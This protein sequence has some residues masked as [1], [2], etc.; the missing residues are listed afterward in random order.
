MFWR[1]KKKTT[2]EAVPAQAAVQPLTNN[3]LLDRWLEDDFAPA[4]ARISS[5]PADKIGGLF[6]ASGYRVDTLPLSATSQDK[7]R[8]HLQ[9]MVD[10]G[11]ANFILNVRTGETFH[12]HL[13]GHPVEISPQKAN[14]AVN[15]D[16]WIDLYCCAVLLRDERAISRLLETPDDLHGKAHRPADQ[17]DLD[18]VALLKGLEQEDSDIAALVTRATQSVY[19][20]PFDEV[21][22]QY[23]DEVLEPALRVLE[24]LVLESGNN[25]QELFQKALERHL[26]YYQEINQGTGDGN[27]EHFSPLLSAV[28][29][30]AGNKFEKAGNPTHPLVPAWLIRTE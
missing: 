3:Q 12:V 4:I 28:G 26:A 13:G 22:M 19:N 6:M 20:T 14:R 24:N 7:V 30:W 9:A 21:R 16:Q 8:K 17:F 1:K 27:K 25:W 5:E 23:T 29:Y 15:S 10:F 2:V 11:V 18:M